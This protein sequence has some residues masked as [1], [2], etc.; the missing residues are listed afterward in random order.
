MFIFVQLLRRL[1]SFKVILQS[2][3]YA[4]GVL[5]QQQILIEFCFICR[6]PVELYPASVKVMLSMKNT[7]FQSVVL[8]TLLETQ[9]LECS[10]LRVNSL[11]Y[12]FFLQQELHRGLVT[13]LNDLYNKTLNRKHLTLQARKPEA[14]KTFEPKFEEQ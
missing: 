9:E 14:I 13:R 3:P 2:C 1:P 12:S 6:I 4:L 11:N 7:L 10:F 5:Y 8:L